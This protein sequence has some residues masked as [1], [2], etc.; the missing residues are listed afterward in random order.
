M[1]CNNGKT[2]SHARNSRIQHLFDGFR[3]CLVTFSVIAQKPDDGRFPNLSLADPSSVSNAA[4]LPCCVA[5]VSY[6]V[7]PIVLQHMMTAPSIDRSVGR[8]WNKTS[9]AIMPLTCRPAAS[10]TLHEDAR[11]AHKQLLH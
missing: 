3:A 6:S 8:S 9:P 7:T 1:L 4:C 2:A 11:F 5:W 10:A